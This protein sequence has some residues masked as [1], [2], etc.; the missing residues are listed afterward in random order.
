MRIPD[1]TIDLIREKARIEEIVKNYVPT[2]K[3]KGKDFV[4]LCPFHKEKTPSFTV[5][6]VKQ[7][8]YCFGCHAGGNVFSFISRI[9][10]LTFPESVKYVSRLVG[11]EI[12]DDKD[13]GKNEYYENIRRLNNYALKLYHKYLNSPHGKRGY[14]YLTGRGVSAE[15]I[16]EFQLGYSPDSWDFLLTNLM[17][18]GADLK[19]AESIGLLK[20][21]KKREKGGSY[22]S[23]RDRVIFPIFDRNS[24][25][26]AFGGRIVGDANPKYL[27]S[28][29]SDV[30]KKRNV[31]YGLDIARDHIRENDRAIVVEG[32]LDVI[33]CHQAG[34]KNVIAPLGTALTLEQVKELSRYCS[35]IIMLFDADAA[36]DNA[37]VRSLKFHEEISVE[38]RVAMLPEG[39]PFD[40]IKEKGP[41]EFMHIVDSA[42][43]PADFSINRILNMEG[44]V[45]MAHKLKMLFDVVSWAD[46]ETERSEFLKNIAT[47]TGLDEN[48]LRKDY[49]RYTGNK[50]APVSSV[51]NNK[52]E[53][54]ADFFTRS[55]RDLVT[56]LCRYPDLIEKAVFD[57]SK[58]KITDDISRNI[59]SRLV[60]LHKTGESFH[61]NKMFDFFQDD[62]EMDFLNRVLNEEFTLEDPDSAY[63]EIY[64]NIKLHEIDTRISTIVQTIK[65]SGTSTMQNHIAELEILRREREKYSNYIQGNR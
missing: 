38:I 21:S 53:G 5:S 65:Q 56:L 32:Y 11:I 51:S 12:H 39:D 60:H 23:F 52:P 1:E 49:R 29:E 62:S 40:Y 6:P 19:L 30:F 18:H 48:S 2:L 28:P 15:S 37:A 64:V 46:Y 42:L 26:I 9:E 44:E 4:G 22:D 27:N 33:G 61:I 8:F 17:K 57:Y 41:R 16:N 36:G 31:L 43:R 14:E 55:Y 13:S 34:F 54:H 50:N 25:V 3:K 24:R 58:D 47:R 10:G 35:E 63:K 59:F 45:P 7:I 20:S